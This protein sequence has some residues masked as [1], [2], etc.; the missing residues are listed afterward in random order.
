[1]STI[2]LNIYAKNNKKI[3]EKTYTVD[4]Y[5]LMLGTVEEFVQIIDV[6]KLNDNA[7]VAGMVLKCYSKIKPLIKDIFPDITDEELDR[8]KVTELV[9]V[10]IDTGMSVAENF[11]YL[12][13]GNFKRA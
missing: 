8:V 10:I 12:K 9:Q 1:M 11:A 2:S 6:D 4:G 5:D 7:A 13:S 3:V